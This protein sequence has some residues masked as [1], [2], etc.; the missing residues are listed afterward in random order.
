MIKKMKQLYK[1]I[2]AIGRRRILASISHSQR[3]E[4]FTA[5]RGVKC[6]FVTVKHQWI[7]IN[8][9]S[10]DRTIQ[11]LWRRWYRKLPGIALWV[12]S[13]REVWHRCPPGSMAVVQKKSDQSNLTENL[14]FLWV[15]CIFFSQNY[16]KK[17]SFS[18]E[19]KGSFFCVIPILKCLAETRYGLENCK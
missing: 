19:F 13:A 15:F 4:N 2:Q 10:R 3:F 18:V 5:R 12:D 9:C 8:Y 16:H 17:D 6:N 11:S 1:I 7:F 14:Y